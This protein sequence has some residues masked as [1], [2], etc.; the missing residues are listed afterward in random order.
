MKLYLPLDAHLMC[1]P[2]LM[3]VSLSC[4]ERRIKCCDHGGTSESDACHGPGGSSEYYYRRRKAEYE[5]LPSLRRPYQLF[6]SSL[7]K[8]E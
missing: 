3:F 8:A 1:A 2:S 5:T 6:N 4:P 7:G